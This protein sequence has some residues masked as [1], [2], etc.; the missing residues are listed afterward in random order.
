MKRTLHYCLLL[1]GLLLAGN[2]VFAQTLEERIVNGDFEGSDYSSFAINVKDEG[3]RDLDAND[4]V[5]DDDDANN[6]CARITK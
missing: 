5:V 6:H 1:A 4:I 2:G 3:S